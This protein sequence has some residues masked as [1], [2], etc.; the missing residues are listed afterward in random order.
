MLYRVSPGTTVRYGES[1]SRNGLDLSL[2]AGP[3]PR[4]PEESVVTL[5]APA[6]PARRMPSKQDRNI[7]ATVT[8]SPSGSAGCPVN[9]RNEIGQL[10]IFASHV[11]PCFTQPDQALLLAVPDRNNQLAVCRQLRHEC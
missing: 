8:E 7:L 3:V 2:T 6:H 1:G 9:E 5:V 10:D 4:G 11:F